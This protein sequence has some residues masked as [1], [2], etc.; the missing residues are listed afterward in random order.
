MYITYNDKTE[1][2]EKF[3]GIALDDYIETVI[4][5][6]ISGKVIV[7]DMKTGESKVVRE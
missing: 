3:N 2:W 6:K 5:R 4:M 7:L 1:L